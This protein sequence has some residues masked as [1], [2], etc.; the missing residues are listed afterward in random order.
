MKRGPEIVK[1]VIK[2]VCGCMLLPGV[3]MDIDTIA[4]YLLNRPVM[5]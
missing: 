4:Y 5:E 2:I 1:S 3:D